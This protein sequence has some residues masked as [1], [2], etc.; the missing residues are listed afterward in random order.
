M[1]IS[2]LYERL[3]TYGGNVILAV[4][5]LIIGLKLI[6]FISRK[7]A[8]KLEKAG[9]DPTLA[10]FLSPLVRA[11][12]LIL[13][14][15]SI[16][17]MLGIAVAS[18]VVVLAAASFAVGLA[19]QGSLSNF[20]G[21]VLIL[22]LKPF[23]VDDYIEA[24]GFAGTVQEIQIFYTVLNTPDNKRII[25]PNA[26]LSNSSIINYSAN[27]TRRIDFSFG[28][29]Y[30]ADNEHVKGLLKQIAGDNPLLFDDPPP[31][32]LLAE[33][34]DSAVIWYLRAWCKRDDYWTIYFDTLEKVKLTFDKEGINIPYPQRDVHIKAQ[35]PGTLS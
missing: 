32:V 15:I 31:Q 29:S 10:N 16:A 27:D 28:V 25:I 4:I 21:G 23:K 1:D 7:V 14:I 30:E 17:S 18:F 3:I 33:H 13:L 6:T 24:S 5:F 12:L 8:Q 26:A 9:A 34:G 22:I 11:V 19:L 35:Q 2:L 20:A